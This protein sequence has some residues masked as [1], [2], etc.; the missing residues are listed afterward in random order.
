MDITTVGRPRNVGWIRAAGILYGDWG[1]S[2]AYVLGIGLSLVGFAALPFALGVCALTG[3]VG[4]AYIIVCKNFPQG[5]GV[6]AAAR[7]ISPRLAML[8][9]LLLLAD[10][11]VTAALSCLDAF[12]YLGF[13]ANAARD[14]AILAI[15]VVGI[16]NSMGPKHM[17]LAAVWL[18]LPAVACVI[19]MI[20]AGLPHLGEFHIRMPSETP[21][22]QWTAFVGMILALSGVEAIANL[23]GVMKLDRGSSRIK[24]KVGR[25]SRYA[26]LAVMS[27]VVIGTAI[28]AV[29]V[30]CLPA[31]AEEHTDDLLR[32]MGT[33]FVGP[34]F[35]LVVGIVFGLLLLSAVNTAINGMVAVLYLMAKEEELPSPFTWLNTSGVPWIPLI[36]ATALPAVILL[37]VSTVDGLADLYAIGVVGAI[38]IT[39]GSCAWNRKLQIGIHERWF[40][41]GVSLLL[42]FVWVTIAATKWEAAAFAGSIVAAGLGLRE[43]TRWRRRQQ[44]I[45]RAESIAPPERLLPAPTERSE[46]DRKPQGP[47]ILLVARRG[48]P[49]VDYALAAAGRRDANLHVMFLKEVTATV[50]HRVKEIDPEAIDFFEAA[51]QSVHPLPIHPIYASTDDPTTT[52]I[53]TAAEIHAEI[54]YMCGSHHPF[55]HRLMKGNLLYALSERLP[56]PV[57][58][59]YIR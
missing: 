22:Q 24:P 23:T 19:I 51:K 20:V 32:Y 49:T 59:I 16:L 15:L 34:G 53:D 12:I 54:I 48:S 7:L 6:Y 50:V 5:G 9:A 2:K 58:L 25:T 43:F 36:L 52:I 26:L 14:Y 37:L 8:G 29:L 33:H 40:L 39:L 17:G 31:A 41:G 4:L 3:L 18:A 38:T 44:Q 11:L 1:T 55:F 30:Q 45:E 57:R 28:L 13:S 10:Y 56:P 47:H 42:A 35:G 21:W 46:L 27:E